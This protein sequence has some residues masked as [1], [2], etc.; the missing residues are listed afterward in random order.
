MQYTH[1]IYLMNKDIITVTDDEFKAIQNDLI[2]RP[3]GFITVQGQ[4]INKS[5]IVK[6]G[7]HHATA[8]IRNIERQDRET[9]LKVGGGEKMLI[10]EKLK[11]KKIAIESALKNKVLIGKEFEEWQRNNEPI[12]IEEPKDNY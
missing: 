5:S 10:S 12:Q 11:E 1:A 3:T 6:L 2:K 4:T 8:L 7:D 9:N